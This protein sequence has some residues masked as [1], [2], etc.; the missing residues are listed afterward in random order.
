MTTALR[1]L[2]SRFFERII[3][4]C[5]KLVCSGNRPAFLFGNKFVFNALSNIKMQLSAFENLCCANCTFGH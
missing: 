5:I 2:S 3:E 1:I 4:K